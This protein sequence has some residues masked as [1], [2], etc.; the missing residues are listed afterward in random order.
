MTR[1]YSTL[2]PHILFFN[3]LMVQKDNEG[4]PMKATVIIP[5]ETSS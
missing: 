2:F 3:E 1:K 4:W 5:E